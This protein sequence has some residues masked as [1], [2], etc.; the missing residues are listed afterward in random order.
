[1]VVLLPRL[2]GYTAQLRG[3]VYDHMVVMTIAV[4]IIDFMTISRICATTMWSHLRLF[5]HATHYD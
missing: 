1:M 4:Y 5:G 2:C 3:C